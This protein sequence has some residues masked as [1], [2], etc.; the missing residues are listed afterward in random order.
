MNQ[1]RSRRFRT[2]QE[3]KEGVQKA[4]MRGEEIPDSPPFDSNCITPGTAFM[5]KL[6]MQLEYFIAKKVNEDADWRGVEVI[7]SGHETCGEGEHKIMEFI[8]TLKAQPGYDPNTRHCLYGLDADLIMLGLLS[9]DP[10]FALLR[11]EVTFGPRRAKKSIGVEAQ[12]F[13]LLHLSLLREYLEL[14]FADMRTKLPFEFDIERIIDDYILLHLFVGNDFLPHLPGLHINE[15]AIELLFRVYKQVL[16]K[17]GGY[18]NEGGTLR[19]DRLQLVIEALSEWDKSQFVATHMPQVER[20]EKKRKKL[21]PTKIEALSPARAEVVKQFTAFI[22]SFFA[23]PQGA[24]HQLRLSGVPQGEAL[25]MI[26]DL[27]A[28][29]GLEYSPRH[30]DPEDDK[31]Y[32]F[33]CIPDSFLGRVRGRNASL[34]EEEIT[35]KKDEMMQ[36]LEPYEKA[37]NG[38]QEPAPPPET[39]AEHDLVDKHHKQYKAHYYRDKMGIRSDDP[40]EMHDLVYNYAEGMQWV[41]HYYYDGNVSWGWFYRYH[42]APQ[43]SDMTNISNFTFHF[44]KGRPFLPFEQLMGVLPPLSMQLIPPAFQGLMTEATSPIL[45]F[46]PTQYESDMNGKKN[47]WEAVVKIPFI[48]EKRLLEALERRAGGL[49]AEERERNT[50]GAPKRFVFD[51]AY[52]RTMP[53]SLPGFLPD[54]PENHTRINTYVLPSMEGKTFV[55]T[56]PK[57]VQL[58]LD[59]MPGFPSIKT[60]PHEHK[61]M[62]GGVNVHGYETKDMSMMLLFKERQPPNGLEALAKDMI[63]RTTYMH[64]PY[65][66]EGLV[67]GVSDAHATIAAEWRGGQIEHRKVSA[68]MKGHAFDKQVS[69]MSRMY[70]SKYGIILQNVAA[71]LH[72][73]PLKG[74]GHGYDGSVV[75]EYEPS[76]MNEMAYPYTLMVNAVRRPDSRFAERPPMTVAEEYPDGTKVFFLG[77][78]GFGCPARVIGTAADHIAVELAFMKDMTQEQEIIR[79][80]VRRRAQ[81]T[82]YPSADV[83]HKL[84]VS[85]ISLAKLTSSMSVVDHNQ[86]Y[87]VGLNLKFEA[88]GRKVLGYSR[89]TQKGWEF[90]ERAVDLVRDMLTAFPELRHGLTHR[91]KDGEFYTVADLFPGPD[92][93]KRFAEL[94]SWIK[95]HNVKDM[96]DVPVY[97]DRLDRSV[98]STLESAVA[99]IATKRAQQGG[100][101]KRQILRGLPRGTLLKPEQA[102]YRVPEQS[103]ELG[104]RVISVLDFGAIPLAAKGTVIG[105]NARSVDVVFDAPFLAGTT[106]GGVCSPHRGATVPT[107]SV[108]NLSTPQIATHWGQETMRD[109][110]MTPL[111]RTLQPR[112]TDQPKEKKGSLFYQPASKDKNPRRGIGAGAPRPAEQVNATAA[113]LAALSLQPQPPPSAWVKPEAPPHAQVHGKSQGSQGATDP[114]RRPKSQGQ[115]QGPSRASRPRGQGRRGQVRPRNP[116][117][118]VPKHGAQKQRPAPSAPPS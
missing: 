111:E 110:K 105:I 11:E 31:M 18:L 51:P 86:R 44:E 10:H 108:L 54:L 90:S 2:A 82:Y 61:L 45:D 95:Q 35:E 81:D 47:S 71:V 84:R 64:W 57:G 72:V 106:L 59:A 5:R 91:I 99:I 83:A 75:K 107:D 37:A 116:T 46:Y 14:E 117:H 21:G 49:T 93:A 19:L 109:A 74:L 80:L 78:P 69:T 58:G 118:H 4:L 23:D 27:C 113:H 73:R 70:R 77:V 100:M 16:P 1:Q 62:V 65:L 32:S 48:D 26:K 87:N 115:S 28:H 52:S 94:R 43:I 42:Y 112:K 3:A 76:P 79:Q 67:V 22:T 68:G 103:F 36:L 50:L 66:F 92:G 15:G 6:S 33:V 30:W 13:Y 104:D 63:G 9:H 29:L 38:G 53:S 8:R 89:R 25:E 114:P 60:L 24:D 40:K 96:D 98:I 41:L 12:T 17:A 85:S 20:Q 7:L 102:R 101:I 34:T 88:R 56:L 55:K 97:V 39:P